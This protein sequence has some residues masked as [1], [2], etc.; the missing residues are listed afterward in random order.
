VSDF[1]EEKV[2]KKGELSP[3]DQWRNIMR[4]L[5]DEIFD[6]SL[7]TAAERA[8]AARELLDLQRKF[9]SSLPG[10]ELRHI[11]K[12]RVNQTTA[13]NTPQERETVRQLSDHMLNEVARKRLGMTAEEWDQ[14]I[15][16]ALPCAQKVADRMR[17]RSEAEERRQWKEK[18]KSRKSRR[19]KTPPEIM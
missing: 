11:I 5:V 4:F 19:G 18:E 9:S 13:A 12:E 8:E 1:S 6:R 16:K 15:E 7:Q 2:S 3:L 14:L 10:M 17:T